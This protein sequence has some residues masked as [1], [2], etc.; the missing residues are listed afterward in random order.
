MGVI[1]DLNHVLNCKKGGVVAAQHIM[2][3]KTKTMTYVALPVYPKLYLNLFYMNQ[4]M[5][6]TKAA[7]KLIGQYGDL[8]TPERSVVRHLHTKC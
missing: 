4:K 1:F 8:G 2:R 6:V 7:C 5:I 3:Q